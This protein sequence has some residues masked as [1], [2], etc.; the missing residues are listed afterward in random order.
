MS[1]FTQTITGSLIPISKDTFSRYSDLIS[2]VILFGD[3]L[4]FI[5]LTWYFDH[6]VESNR[7]RG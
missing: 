7:G 3:A 4:F 2:M 5:I 6:V 1:V